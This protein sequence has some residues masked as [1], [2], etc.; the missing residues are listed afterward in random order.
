MPETT[1]YLYLGLG[2]M[3]SVLGLYI[4]SLVLRMRNALKDIELITKLADES[5]G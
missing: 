2:V 5:E 3:F 1:A 4:V